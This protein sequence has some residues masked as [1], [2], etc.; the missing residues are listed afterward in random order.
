[1]LYDWY[2]DGLEGAGVNLYLDLFVGFPLAWP[3]SSTEPPHRGR[4]QAGQDVIYKVS[5]IQGLD[6]KGF[7]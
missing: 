7:P 2:T 3:E 4:V 6:N 5:F 1:M